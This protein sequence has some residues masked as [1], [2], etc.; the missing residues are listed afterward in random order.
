[1][2]GHVHSQIKY[3][4]DTDSRKNLLRLVLYPRKFSGTVILHLA[5]SPKFGDRVDGRLMSP[6]ISGDRNFAFG[7]VPE[8]RDRRGLDM[9]R[10]V[11]VPKTMYT[12]LIYIM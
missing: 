7:Y 6:K 1:M 10:K 2:V 11:I 4:T 5:M 9:S 8:I 12:N 3:V